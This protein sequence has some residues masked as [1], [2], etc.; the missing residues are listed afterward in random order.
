ML[1]SLVMHFVYL[2]G[3]KLDSF[4]LLIQLLI[5]LLQVVLLT[6]QIALTLIELLLTL[7]QTLVL[8]L[9]LALVL[10]HHFLVLQLQCD[11][12]L[13]GL[14]D[15]VLLDHLGFLL[16][17]LDQSHAR[18]AHDHETYAGSKQERYNSDNYYY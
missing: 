1:L 7:L 12:F 10:A 13:L 4:E 14:H 11:E 18:E 15:L 2:L 8:L 3:L 9:L 16:G 17:L 5:A 6:L